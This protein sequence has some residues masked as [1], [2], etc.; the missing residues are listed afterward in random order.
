MDGRAVP[1]DQELARYLAEGVLE[2]VNHVLAIKSP[3][4]LE[5]QQLS[6]KGDTAH[7]REVITRELLVEDGC[8][9]HR[10]VGAHEA[11]KQV[12]AALIHEH[13]RPNLPQGPLSEKAPRVKHE[14]GVYLRIQGIPVD[15]A[16]STTA[17]AGRRSIVRNRAF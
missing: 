3:L 16:H 17:M 1:H 12:E 5:H 2:E 10:S 8:L 7:G 4:L 13:Y 14:C 11:G 9:A 6:L 15:H